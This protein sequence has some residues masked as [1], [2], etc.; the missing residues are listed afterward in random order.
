MI[1]GQG[2]RGSG[3]PH[4]A[5]GRLAIR[6]G[7]ADSSACHHHRAGENGDKGVDKQRN[8]CTVIDTAKLG[9][10]SAIQNLI[11]FVS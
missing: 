10:A 6:L 5:L 1:G 11:P 7:T 8:F 2:G 3:V 9:R 4:G